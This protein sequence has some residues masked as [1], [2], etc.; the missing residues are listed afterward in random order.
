MEAADENNDL[1]SR[2]IAINSEAFAGQ[3]FEV[4]YHTLVAAFQCARDSN[5]EQRIVE[6][7]RFANEQIDWIDQHTPEH[8]L[9]SQSAHIRGNE[10][11][12]KLLVDQALAYVHILHLKSET[13]ADN[14]L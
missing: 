4:A 13:L 1:Y 2:L 5:A 3:H 11:V 8:H 10:S 12:F 9:S 14:P 7:E 6:V